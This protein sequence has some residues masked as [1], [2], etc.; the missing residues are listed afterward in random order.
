M[1]C[2]RLL[3]AWLP[4]VLRYFRNWWKQKHPSIKAAWIG[5]IFVVIAGTITVGPELLTWY[6]GV[7]ERSLTQSEAPKD[8]KA[9]GTEGKADRKD[10]G[11]YST[12]EY[13][14]ASNARATQS[15]YSVPCVG[16][17]ADGM[18]HPLLIPPTEMLEVGAPYAWVYDV[19]VHRPPPKPLDDAERERLRKEYRVA[20]RGSTVF[21]YVPNHEFKM[22]VTGRSRYSL[23]QSSDGS[24]LLRYAGSPASTSLTYGKPEEEQDSSGNVLKVQMP[25]G[26][27]STQRVYPLSCLG[28][29]SDGVSFQML[30]D[31]QTL[32]QLGRSMV[33][34]G[35]ISPCPPPNRLSVGIAMKTPKACLLELYL[36]EVVVRDSKITL[37][38]NGTIR[39]EDYLRVA[40]PADGP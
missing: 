10:A 36:Y 38:Y 1:Q 18:L 32:L 8:G 39:S 27:F 21:M 34:V 2:L 3:W 4:A 13:T 16:G 31:P 40:K 6:K 25:E 11:S 26:N 19:Q 12:I 5:G 22:E 33:W 29:P 7:A 14:K 30:E 15:I 23:E 35:R 28:G 9:P 17:P 24:F 37:D 20:K